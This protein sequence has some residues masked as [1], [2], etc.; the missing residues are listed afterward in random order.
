M[1][2]DL[3]VYLHNAHLHVHEGFFIVVCPATRGPWYDNLSISK[4]V[5]GRV[6]DDPTVLKQ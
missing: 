5:L 3:P 6:S 1:A 2:A 4:G